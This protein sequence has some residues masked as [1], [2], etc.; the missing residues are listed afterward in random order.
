M[1]VGRHEIRQGHTS[2]DVVWQR[3]LSTDAEVQPVVEEEVAVEAEE[4][5]VPQVGVEQQ[6]EPYIEYVEDPEG[7]YWGQNDMQAL[8]NDM[9]ALRVAVEPP[10]PVVDVRIP[11]LPAPVPEVPVAAPPAVVRRSRRLQ[12]SQHVMPLAQQQRRATKMAMMRYVVK[13]KHGHGEGCTSCQ[14]A[15][16]GRGFDPIEYY[17]CPALHLVCPPCK[18]TWIVR[19][20]K[21]CPICRQAT[22]YTDLFAQEN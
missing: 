10:V 6:E 14:N 7:M 17:A 22:A 13:D 19:M 2:Y 9:Q 8:Q 1:E 18:A 16:I 5:Q 11:P 20:A 21:S 15:D 4:V 3:Y 12:Q